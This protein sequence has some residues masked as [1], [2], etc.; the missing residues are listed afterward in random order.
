M[1]MSCRWILVS[2][3]SSWLCIVGGRDDKINIRAW[4]F[5]ARQHIRTMCYSAHNAISMPSVCLFFRL[6]VT[7]GSVKNSAS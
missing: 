7:G 1:I 3:W 5:S 4:F 6:S 2:W